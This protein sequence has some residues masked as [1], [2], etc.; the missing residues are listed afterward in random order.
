[1]ETAFGKLRC[2]GSSDQ[3]GQVQP[4][5][6]TCVMMQALGPGIDANDIYQMI[7]IAVSSVTMQ[8][9]QWEADLWRQCFKFLEPICFNIGV[10]FVV[11]LE[12]YCIAS[13]FNRRFVEENMLPFIFYTRLALECLVWVGLLALLLCLVATVLPV[14]TISLLFIM[15]CMGLPFIADKAAGLGVGNCHLERAVLLCIPVPGSDDAV[16][17]N[18]Y[19]LPAF[20]LKWAWHLSTVFSQRCQEKKQPHQDRQDQSRSSAWYSYESISSALKWPI[21]VTCQLLD[22][23]SDVSV[24]LASWKVLPLWWSVLF[25]PTVLLSGYSLCMVAAQK[26]KFVTEN[27]FWSRLQLCED[28]PQALLALVGI[29]LYAGLGVPQD[30]FI[31]TTVADSMLDCMVQV[32]LWDN[33]PQDRLLLPTDETG[34]LTKNTYHEQPISSARRCTIVSI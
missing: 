13:C 3:D 11:V 17:L 23:K 18:Y 19:V 21:E 1:N 22:V 15:G 6:E 33:H 34:E 12:L 26:P 28:I 20:V 16:P 8:V 14:V 10:C 9:L 25:A 24:A 7:V 2:F 30:P 31:V 29:F 32:V 4:T 27:A 5:N